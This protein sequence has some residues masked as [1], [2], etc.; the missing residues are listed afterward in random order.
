MLPLKGLAHRL[1]GNTFIVFPIILVFLVVFFWMWCKGRHLAAT[2][3]SG[4]DSTRL[5]VHVG[6]F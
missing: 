4:L 3:S 1:N 2:F 6:Q 5:V